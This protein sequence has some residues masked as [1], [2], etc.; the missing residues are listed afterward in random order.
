MSGI[1]GSIRTIRGNLIFFIQKEKRK[2][3]KINKINPCNIS[4]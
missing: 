1:V 3:R 2:E 4:A